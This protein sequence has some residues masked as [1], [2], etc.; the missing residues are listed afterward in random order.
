MSNFIGTG[1]N[2]DGPDLPLGLGMQLAQNPKAMK[3]FGKMT[4]MEKS[5]M[6]AHIQASKTGDEAK[7]RLA[8]A[9]HDLGE[10]KI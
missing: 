8:Q 7:T 3:A 1:H 4:N 5:K 6:I 10:N 9:V 2:P